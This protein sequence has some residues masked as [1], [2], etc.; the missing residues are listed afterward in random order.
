MCVKKKKSSL[1]KESSTTPSLD[2]VGNMEK[3]ISNHISFSWFINNGYV[4]FLQQQ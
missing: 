2:G 1:G 3:N 4:K